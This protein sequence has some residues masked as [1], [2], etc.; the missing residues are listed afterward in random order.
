VL[1]VRVENDVNPIGPEC[2]GNR[3]GDVTVLDC[4]F[5]ERSV[6]AAFTG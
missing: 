2:R 6:P 4:S 3:L 1:D 5:I